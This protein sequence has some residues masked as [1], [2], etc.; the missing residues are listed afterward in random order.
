MGQDVFFKQYCRSTVIRY[1][2]VSAELW[3]SG[4]VKLFPTMWHSKRLPLGSH[5]IFIQV[6]YS[7]I[8][9]LCCVSQSSLSEILNVIHHIFYSLTLSTSFPCFSNSQ[10]PP[11]TLIPFSIVFHLQL[12]HPLLKIFHYRIACS[13]HAPHTINFWHVMLL[14]YMSETHRIRFAASSRPRRMQLVAPSEVGEIALRTAAS[15]PHPLDLWSH[16]ESEER[17]RLL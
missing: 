9:T 16:G 17:S 14:C 3:M 1:S 10:F 4:W 15:S 5:I 7:A 6:I 12:L 13:P 8:S 2:S 11:H